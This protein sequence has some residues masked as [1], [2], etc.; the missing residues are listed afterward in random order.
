MK[1][2]LDFFDEKEVKNLQ[3][4][5]VK[6]EDNILI[7]LSNHINE[8]TLLEFLEFEKVKY[9]REIHD[10]LNVIIDCHCN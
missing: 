9:L 4:C 8:M 2:V 10:D 5:F 6:N 1:N 3:N 7:Q